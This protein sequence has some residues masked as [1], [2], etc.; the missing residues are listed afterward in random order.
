MIRFRP[1][2]FLIIFIAVW[3]AVS[4][5]Q[6]SRMITASGVR[7]RASPSVNAK[8][9]TQVGVGIT[10]KV[11]AQS[12]QPQKIGGNQDYWYQLAL[13]NGKKGWVFGT[14]TTPYTEENHPQ[15]LAQVIQKRLERARL[16]LSEVQESMEICAYTARFL[17]V[18]EEA[19][20]L[21][22]ARLRLL[23]KGLDQLWR[24]PPGSETWRQAQSEA[25]YHHESAGQWFVKPEKWWALFGTFQDQPIAETIAWTAATAQT[26]G[27]CEG[28]PP[29][30]MDRAN[31]TTLRYLTHFPNGTRAGE[32]WNDVDQ[33]LRYILEQPSPNQ[34][35]SEERTAM[36]TFFKSLQSVLKKSTVPERES[37]K[38]SLDQ[39]QA[40]IFPN[41]SSNEK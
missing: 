14:L 4:A 22:F 30:M 29:C 17:G 37:C 21:E 16:P 11:L 31:G 19:G 35:E 5:A 20:Q 13:E 26:P 6:E 18:S 27:E 10:G 25:I 8:E 9:I 2:R 12:Q 32:A 41:A 40:K 23:Q 3:S 34:L 7:L 28:W 33:M 15:V 1:W 38:T 24:A 36:E 39:V